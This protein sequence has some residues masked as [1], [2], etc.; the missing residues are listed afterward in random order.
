MAGVINN[1]IE[2][3][4]KRGARVFS[5]RCGELN[6]CRSDWAGD[7]EEEEALGWKKKT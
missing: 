2:L 3:N 4:E 6:T 5:S 1:V 7:E